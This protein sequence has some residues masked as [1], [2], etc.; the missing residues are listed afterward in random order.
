MQANVKLSQNSQIVVKNQNATHNGNKKS[1]VI[2]KSFGDS[3]PTLI[4]LGDE[5]L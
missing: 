4:K 3:V 1:F 2:K 5:E